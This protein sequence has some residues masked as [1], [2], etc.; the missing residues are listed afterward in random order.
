MFE[1]EQHTFE[2]VSQVTGKAA[3]NSSGAGAY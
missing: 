3:A 1:L 2:H